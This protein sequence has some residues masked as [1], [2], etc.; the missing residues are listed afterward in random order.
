MIAGPWKHL[1]IE[2]ISVE[3]N[4]P[5]YANDVY[6]VAWFYKAPFIQSLVPYAYNGQRSAFGVSENQNPYRGIKFANLPIIN[7]QANTTHEIKYVVFPYR[8]DKPIPDGNSL[9]VLQRIAAI[10]ATF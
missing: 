7:F 6:T 10:K 8:Y 3:N 5:G 4:R 2:W 9:T 1:E